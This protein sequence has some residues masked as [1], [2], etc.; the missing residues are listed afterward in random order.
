M[1]GAA[2][3]KLKRARSAHRIIRE[4]AFL[5]IFPFAPHPPLKSGGCASWENMHCPEI[6]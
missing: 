2:A 3:K 6:R 4:E 5:T 1:G